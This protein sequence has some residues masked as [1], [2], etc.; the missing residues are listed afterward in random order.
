[1]STVTT[2]QPAPA[3]QVE[4]AV[5][6]LLPVLQGLDRSDLA[7]RATAALARLKR[8]A[9]IVCIVGE[10]KQGKSSLVNGLL[11]QT[12]CPVDDDLATS[13]LTLLRYGDE[14]GAVVR[15]KVDDQ[16][17]AERVDIGAVADWA[18]EQGNPGNRQQVERV[19]ISVPSAMLKQGLVLVDTPGMGGLGA[20]HA[21]AT[22]SFLPFADGL[23]LVSDASQE[24]SAPEIAFLRQASE[25]CPTVLLAQTKIDLYPQWQRIV[26]L[27]RGHLSR[28]GVE[29]PIV[30]VSS[31]LRTEALTRRDRELNEASHF[32]E[33]IASLG[34]EVIEPAK[35]NALARSE[36]DLRGVV[37]LARTSLDGQRRVLDDPASLQQALA[38]LARAKER[39]DHLRG[40][41]AKWATVVNDRVTDLNNEVNFKFR[42]ATR[43][44]S[45]AMDEQV[46]VLTTGTAWDEMARSLQTAVATEVTAA[47][48][49]IEV[50]RVAIQSEVAELLQDEHLA[51]PSGGHH[52]DPID[53]ASLW[54]G[55]PIGEQGSKG[56]KAVKVGL[57]GIRGAQSGVMMFGMMGQ[58]LPVAAATLVASNPVLLG[59]GALFGGLQL[60]EER[61]RKLQVLRQGARGQVRQFLDDVQFEVGNA[62]AEVIREVQRELRDGFSER[63]GEL[64]RTYTETAQ[65]AQEDANRGQ[66]E[67][68]A[69]RKQV[70]AALAALDQVDTVLRRAG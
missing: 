23:V 66:A 26:D 51:L 36:A 65:R 12:L 45:R 25:L 32:P 8:P 38:D 14:P 46:E 58:F 28:A 4:G 47:F 40:P 44:I 63:L 18:T 67:M 30:A 41:G 52:L 57:T 21:A 43:S 53:V 37:G 2:D 68:D 1:M 42:A 29:L 60:G 7:N 10:F 35:A 5:G 3:A 62:V 15:R 61:K 48:Q 70:A 55:K 59:A 13:A 50:G 20:G 34:Q 27:N 64:Q 33:L 9:T 16:A 22:L 39:I 19:E 31:L 49:A 24:L 54:Q 11:G 6:T 56:G 69:R 17:V